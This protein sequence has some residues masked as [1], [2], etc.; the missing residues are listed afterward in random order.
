MTREGSARL[1]GHHFV[2]LQFYRG[3]G[4]SPPFVANLNRIVELVAGQPALVVGGADDVCAACPGLAPDSS[5]IDP[6]AGEV[7]V[8]R[9]DRL[10]FV[11]LGVAPGDTL[12][13]AEARE[14]L[15]VDVVAIGRWR[16]EACA[17]CAWED[18]CEDGWARLLGQAP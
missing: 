13:L 8:R 1:R 12:S 4:Y 17:G 15:S 5:C 10:A 3:E 16:A 9:L 6:S 11:A 14:R 7:E 2:C 18:V